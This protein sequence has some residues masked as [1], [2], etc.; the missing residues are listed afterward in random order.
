MSVQPRA[1]FTN[2]L[3]ALHSKLYQQNTIKSHFNTRAT[4][5]VR[6]MGKLISTVFGNR[7]SHTNIDVG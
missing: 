3:S 6:L 7:K 5:N 1:S 4:Y 2:A